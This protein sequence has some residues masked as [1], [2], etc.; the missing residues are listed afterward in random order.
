MLTNGTNLFRLPQCIILSFPFF[1]ESRGNAILQYFAYRLSELFNDSLVKTDSRFV[2]KLINGRIRLEAALRRMITVWHQST[3]RAIR[4]QTDPMHSNHSRGYFDVIRWSFCA[5]LLQVE[6][7]YCYEW[8]RFGKWSM[9]HLY[10]QSPPTVYW[11]NYVTHTERVTD[12]YPDC[13]TNKV[14]DSEKSHDDVLYIGT[15]L[16]YWHT[17]ELNIMKYNWNQIP[18]QMCTYCSIRLHACRKTNKPEKP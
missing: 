17:Y 5:V 4:E 7:A 8:I 11:P 10:L 13:H 14:S 1:L 3:V 15:I 16:F 2:P 9:T 6:R 18:K 12:K